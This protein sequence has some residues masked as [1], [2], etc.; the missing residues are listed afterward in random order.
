MSK[1]KELS[2]LEEYSKVRI[3]KG[4]KLELI[5]NKRISLKA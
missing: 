5:K 3:C 4:L 2:T 1:K